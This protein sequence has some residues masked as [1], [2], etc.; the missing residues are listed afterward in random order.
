VGPVSGEVK[1]VCGPLLEEG[2]PQTVLV[3]IFG[4]VEG[5]AVKSDLSILHFVRTKQCVSNDFFHI[6]RLSKFG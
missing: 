3:L 5:A 2:L 1:A 6:A 4:E